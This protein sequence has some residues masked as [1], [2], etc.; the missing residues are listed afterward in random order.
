MEAVPSQVGVE[1]TAVTVAFTGVMLSATPLIC[2]V[3][4]PLEVVQ[5]AVPRVVPLVRLKVTVTDAPLIKAFVEVLRRVTWRAGRQVPKPT[6]SEAFEVAL[7]V[8]RGAAVVVVVGAV[9]VVVVG[10]AVVVV[11]G[12]AVVVVGAVV[13]VVVA[14]VVVD[15]AT[16]IDVPVGPEPEMLG[17]AP[18]RL[19]V[20]L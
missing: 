13:V 14:I 10:A 1:V 7:M 8:V 5:V 17:R 12:A 6:V 2:A 11:V 3:Q 9:V 20:V 16:G 18:M 15:D 4:T 19:L